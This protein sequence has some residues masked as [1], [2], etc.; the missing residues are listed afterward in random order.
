MQL[1][2]REPERPLIEMPPKTISIEAVLSI[3]DGLLSLPDNT[4]AIRPARRIAFYVYCQSALSN[5][6]PSHNLALNSLSQQFAEASDLDPATIVDLF[7]SLSEL[8]TSHPQDYDPLRYPGKDNDSG[9]WPF[10]VDQEQARPL[11]NHL[12]SSFDAQVL[13]GDVMAALATFEQIRKVPR[14]V[15]APLDMVL[16]DQDP[17][18]QSLDPASLS[19]PSLAQIEDTID[20]G[21]SQATHIPSS[22]LSAFLKLVISTDRLDIARVLLYEDVFIPRSEA[23]NPVLQPALLQAAVALSDRDLIAQV[24]ENFHEDYDSMSDEILLAV[25][26]THISLRNYYAARRLLVLLGRE[27]R[28]ALP[29]RLTT[30]TACHYITVANAPVSDAEASGSP[31]QRLLVDI[32]N[33]S[34][35]PR[36][37]PS[38]PINYQPQRL[39]AQLTRIFRDADPV[40]ARLP[41][42]RNISNADQLNIAVQIP[43]DAFNPLLET[44]AKI[45]GAGAAQTLFDKWCDPIRPAASDAQTYEGIPVVWPQF[46]GERIVIPTLESVEIVLHSALTELRGFYD[47]PS[48]S[49]LQSSDPARRLLRW[50]DN[51]TL[52]YDPDLTVRTKLPPRAPNRELLEWGAQTLRR[53]GLTDF[54]INTVIPGAFPD[55]ETG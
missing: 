42:L 38:A 37:D 39:L 11:V 32:L 55:A 2:T 31:I 17:D 18:P 27:R 6:V 13:R 29:P 54:D 51:P 23:R 53:M 22:T 40:L 21:S 12:I 33:G 52:V 16:S 15:L 46:E 7:Y 14:D 30:V 36:R 49:R 25:Y 19:Y 45:K 41:G 28:L 20:A 35:L 10:A 24:V 43:A 4:S 47:D 44:L 9:F 34:F 5:P 50:V 48:N 1:L 3:L 8:P 26:E